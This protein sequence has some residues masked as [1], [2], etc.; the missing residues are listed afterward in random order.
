MKKKGAIPGCRQWGGQWVTRNEFNRLVRLAVIR[1]LGDKCCRCGFSDWRALQADHVIA[2]TRESRRYDVYRLYLDVKKSIRENTN[3]Y[4]CLCAN[5]NWI[6]RYENNEH[7]PR[8]VSA[9]LSSGD[10]VHSV[11]TNVN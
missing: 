4:Q 6:K 8:K 5:C 10:S 3:K 9:D 11:N 7:N 1:L 2:S